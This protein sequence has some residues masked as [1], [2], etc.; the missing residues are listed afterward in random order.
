MNGL[1]G[2]KWG[3]EWEEGAAVAIVTGAGGRG[4]WESREGE[5]RCQGNGTPAGGAG[6]AVLQRPGG[7]PVAEPA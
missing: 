5:R 6:L 1:A 3:E 4:R 7:P 2:A